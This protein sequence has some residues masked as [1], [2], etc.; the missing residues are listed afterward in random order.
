[1]P[2]QDPPE[3]LGR[4]GPRGGLGVRDPGKCFS[5]SAFLTEWAY[6]LPG[7]DT[8]SADV[9]IPCMVQGGGEGEEERMVLWL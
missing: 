5:H 3:W 2:L 8:Q 7:A 6:R 9:C 1:M 4:P